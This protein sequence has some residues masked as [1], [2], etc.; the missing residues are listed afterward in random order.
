MKDAQPGTLHDYSVTYFRPTAPRQ[1]LVWSDSEGNSGII[2]VNTS[3]TQDSYFP[4]WITEPN[5]TLYGTRLLPHNSFNQVTGQWSNTPYGWGYADN[6]GSEVAPTEAID[7]CREQLREE[8]TLAV[9]PDS[10]LIQDNLAMISVVGRGMG[11]KSGVC[12]RLF[13]ALGAA[14]IS[15][16]VIDQGSN[17]MN[18]VIGVEEPDYQNAIRAIHREF[19]EQ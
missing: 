14:G 12:A 9:H 13:S 17:E 5:F 3:H 10:L 1:N 7:A 19:F 8:I 16:R 11:H 18:I 2:P 4:A 15:V 6:L